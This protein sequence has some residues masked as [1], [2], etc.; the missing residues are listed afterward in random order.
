M[1][2]R[3][4]TK[5]LHV[6]ESV[7]GVSIACAGLKRRAEARSEMSGKRMEE[8]RRKPEPRKAGYKLRLRPML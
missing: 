8:W 6:G 1:I 3:V 5:K 7:T 2:G 4:R